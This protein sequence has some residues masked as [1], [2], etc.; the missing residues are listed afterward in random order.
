MVLLYGSERWVVTGE[1][2]NVLEEFYHQGERRIT[3]M[4][5]TRG[6]GGEWEYPPVVAAMEGTGNHYIGEYIRGWQVTIVEKVDFLP[7][8]KLC[9]E[10]DQ[11]RGTS[12]MVR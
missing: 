10:A 5:A 7:I 2:L 1:M 9:I 8:Y 4:T 11:M 6:V 12:R 3:G